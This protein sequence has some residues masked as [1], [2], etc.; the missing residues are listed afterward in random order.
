MLDVIGMSSGAEL[1]H[2]QKVSRPKLLRNFF[3]LN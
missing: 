2:D 3:A 1:T